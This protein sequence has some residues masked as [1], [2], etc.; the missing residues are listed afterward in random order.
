MTALATDNFNRAD[1]DVGASWTIVYTSPDGWNVS[2]NQ[3]VPNGF[4]TDAIIYNNTVTWPADQYSQ[5]VFKSASGSASN[6]GAGPIVRSG[7]S[8][9]RNLY[10]MVSNAAGTGPTTYLGKFVAGSYTAL[11][12]DSTTWSANDLQYLEIQGTSL[13][14][15]HAGTTVVSTTDSS[16]SSGN[17]GLAYSSTI[18]S[19][20][21]DDWE[22]G[23]FAAGGGVT[24]PQI[25]HANLRGSMR[26]AFIGS[27]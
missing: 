21:G 8:G 9:S 19:W 25:E 14:G 11:A 5:I 16:L 15:K 3:A 18:T 23:D 24:Y 10:W 6:A 1:G 17:A 7:T 22:G 20:A 12:N 13:V 26:G 27:R 2:S 4:G